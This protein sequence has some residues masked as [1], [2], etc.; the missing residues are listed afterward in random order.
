MIILCNLCTQYVAPKLTFYSS[1]VLFFIRSQHHG[2]KASSTHEENPRRTRMPRGL[3]SGSFRE[4]FGWSSSTVSNSNASPKLSS[5]PSVVEF[6]E[7]EDD[8]DDGVENWHVEERVSA[9]ASAKHGFIETFTGRVSKYLR[10]GGGSKASKFGDHACV[11][12]A[13]KLYYSPL[14]EALTGFVWP[15]D[16][17]VEVP[18]KFDIE[19]TLTEVILENRRKAFVVDLQRPLCVSGVFCSLRRLSS[20]CVFLA[21]FHLNFL[22]ICVG[23]PIFSSSFF[24]FAFL[25]K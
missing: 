7:D 9:K 24:Y 4:P 1:F 10:N 20:S 19:R 16:E 2:H 14:G 13:M 12:V 25:Q 18:S 23:L 6:D 11:K 17:F 15:E 22:V 8:D 5:Q 21:V 3:S